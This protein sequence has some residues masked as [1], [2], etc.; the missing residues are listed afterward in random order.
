M[1]DNFNIIIEDT[2]DI[3]NV[4]VIN[5]PDIFNLVISEKGLDGK[6]GTMPSDYFHLSGGQIDGDVTI[7]GSISAASYLGLP[8]Q[9]DIDN[10]L[11]LSGGNLIGNLSSNSSATFT[12]LIETNPT[13]LKL[14]QTT[15]QTIINPE[16]VGQS[17]QLMDETYAIN[18]LGTVAVAGNN[19]ATYIGWDLTG[20]R[21]GVYSSADGGSGD[22]VVAGYFSDGIGNRVT[23]ANKTYAISTVGSSYFLPR[24]GTAYVQLHT[25]LANFTSQRIG[26]SINTTVNLNTDTEG[27][28]FSDGNNLVYLSDGTYAINAKG[29]SLFT[30]SLSSN[31]S[32]QFAT[33]SA[34]N[35]TFT[36]TVSAASYLGLSHKANLSSIN[37]VF[38]NAG[39]A[40]PMTS[41]ASTATV[42]IA[43]SSVI[44]DS[45][46]FDSTISESVQYMGYLPK[47]GAGTIKAKVAWTYVGT[48]GGTNVGWNITGRAYANDDT[49]DQAFGTLQTISMVKLSANDMHITG[50]TP[51]IT[52]GGTP[53]NG[54]PIVIKVSRD[55][56]VSTN[57]SSDAR[58]LGLWLEYMGS[59][60]EETGW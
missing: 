22:N 27:G 38:W 19:T 15:P 37:H 53:A 30:G 45:F 9:S 57:L 52:L 58:F 4:E 51:A 2:S 6:N 31:S 35:A 34:T 40:I 14:D 54:Q 8:T 50:A 25:G 20:N 42:Q 49:L 43:A 26:S 44:Y 48:P 39:A 29:N 41:S 47:W 16:M 23:L 17:V 46:D 24:T 33:L 11:P 56:T 12:S 1:S 13:L 28:Y 7:T 36:G 60:T 10:Y 18:A 21:Y 55:T 32:G 3:F 59:S 5:Q